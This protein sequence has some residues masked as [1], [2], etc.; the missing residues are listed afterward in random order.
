MKKI[1]FILVMCMNCGALY[2]ECTANAPIYVS[3]KPGYYLENGNCVQCPKSD[4]AGIYGTSADKN[5]GDKTSCYIPAGT[6]FSDAT[7]AGNYE[8]DTNFCD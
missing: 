5:T 3:C 2:A 1:F 7:G 4:L 8:V 6:T